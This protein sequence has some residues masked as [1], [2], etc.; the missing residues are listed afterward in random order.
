MGARRP[1]TCSPESPTWYSWSPRGCRWS[2]RW[3]ARGGLFVIVVV[4]GVAAIAWLPALRLALLSTRAGVDYDFVSGGTSLLN[5][6]QLV[7]PGLLTQWP[8]E[9]VGL[10]PLLLVLIAWFGRSHLTATTA[11]KQPG[12]RAETFFWLVV[13]VVAGWLALGWAALRG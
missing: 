6:L 5:Y 12:A 7:L 3:L 9:Y 2:W 10:L 11:D 1:G 4:A 8:P 13:A